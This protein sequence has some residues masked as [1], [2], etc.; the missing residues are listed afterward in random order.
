MTPGAFALG[1]FFLA[2]CADVFYDATARVEFLCAD[3][4]YD[5]TARVEFLCADVFYDATARVEFLCACA[6]CVGFLGV[7]VSGPRHGF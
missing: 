2:A 3:V 1:V 4:F 5:A 6:E 7:F